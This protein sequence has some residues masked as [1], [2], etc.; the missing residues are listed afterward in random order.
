M[1]SSNASENTYTNTTTVLS[2]DPLISLQVDNILQQ[3]G[4]QGKV[5]ITTIARENYKLNINTYFFGITK[6]LEKN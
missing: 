5:R 3:A 4:K 2:L 6:T 1:E